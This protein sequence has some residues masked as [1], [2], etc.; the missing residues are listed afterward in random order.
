MK[1]LSKRVTVALFVLVLIVSVL[2][3]YVFT[4]TAA[5]RP[6]RVT[7]IIEGREV[8]F[9]PKAAGRIA[10]ICCSEGDTV[11]EGQVLVNLDS[12]DV[13]ALVEQAAAEVEKARTDIGTADAAAETARANILSA[14][15]DM[16]SAAAD[17]EKARAQMRESEREA[18]RASKLFEKGYI[19]RE[20]RDQA[21]TTRD[22]NIASFQS[23]KEKLSA[24]GARKD[25]A[26][27][28]L[29]V[30]LGQLGSS[31][32]GLR[33]AE[34]N[35]SY[36]RSKLDDTIIKTTV[37]GTVIY[38]TLDSGE[39]VAPGVTILTVVDLGSLYAR[40]DIDETKIGGITLNSEAF[41]T[42]QGLPGRT[43]KGRIAEIGRYAEFATQRDVVR[44]REDIK[45]FR[46]KVRMDDTGGL[47]KPGMTVDVSIPVKT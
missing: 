8:N 2:A 11:T 28:Q 14:E 29:K 36:Y 39:T 41:V 30:A 5:V 33:Q 25:A 31:K 20:S 23:A 12:A 18:G 17:A 10:K 13:V 6:I 42:V 1:R 44:G 27:A 21:V 19:S 24:S 3:I 7:G 43:F 34:A 32:A 22:A 38:K 46:V 16:K 40:V 9:A 37:T 35:L 45:T 47:L 26:T 15:G 4:R